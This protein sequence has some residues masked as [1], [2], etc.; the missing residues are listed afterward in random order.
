V[1]P[2]TEIDLLD[3]SGPTAAHTVSDADD[4]SGA[5]NQ[6]T[7]NNRALL[8]SLAKM[9]SNLIH[10]T[11]RTDGMELTVRS[12]NPDLDLLPSTD[13]SL[14]FSLTVSGEIPFFEV[15][16][17]NDRRFLRDGYHR[18]YRLLRPAS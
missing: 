10:S 5:T 15:A 12:P 8:R 7:E 11:Q 3:S 13:P 16:N 1:V 9:T 6:L 4:Y 2:S 14:P 18:A 17:L